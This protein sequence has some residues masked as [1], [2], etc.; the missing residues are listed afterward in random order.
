MIV[1]HYVAIFIAPSKTPPTSVGRKGIAKKKKKARA[2]VHVAIV[3]PFPPIPFLVSI[4]REVKFMEVI[5]W[6]N[7]CVK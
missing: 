6:H 3:F 1:V 2:F 7:K 5:Y 4:E